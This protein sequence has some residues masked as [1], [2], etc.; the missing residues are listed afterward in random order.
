[1][2]DGTHIH[3]VNP[4]RNVRE[5]CAKRAYCP[6]DTRETCAKRARNVREMRECR[7]T[8]RATRETFANRV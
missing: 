1:M 4:S 8:L 7:E 3:T 5:T 6:G 2:R